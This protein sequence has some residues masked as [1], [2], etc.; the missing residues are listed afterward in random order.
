MLTSGLCLYPDLIGFKLNMF[1]MVLAIR[2]SLGGHCD[3]GDCNLIA[4]PVAFLWRKTGQLVL[5][6][7]VFFLVLFCFFLSILEQG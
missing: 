3:H 4:S 5:V 2:R 6:L 7:M 1:V